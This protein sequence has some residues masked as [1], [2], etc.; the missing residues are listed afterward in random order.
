MLIAKNETGKSTLVS[1]LVA[2]IF[3][4]PT[5]NN[6][7]EFGTARFKNWYGPSRFEG[8]LEFQFDSVKYSIW[9]DFESHKISLSVFENDVQRNLV[10][11]EH[12]PGA[13]KQNL[14]YEAWLK[15]LFGI[16]SREV[17]EATF[18]ITQPLPETTKKDGQGQRD[19]DEGVQELLSGT[20]IAFT[21]AK[22]ALFEDFKKQTKFTRERGFSSRDQIRDGELELVEARIEKLKSE[23][24]RAKDVADSLETVRA[25]LNK[26][27]EDLDAKSKELKEKQETRSSFNEWKRLRSEYDQAILNLNKTQKAFDT[28]NDYRNKIITGTAELKRLYPEYNNPPRT[29]ED[30]LDHLILLDQRISVLSEDVIKIKEQLN[31]SKIKREEIRESAKSL[32]CWGELGKNPAAKIKTGRRTAA[33]LL[34]GWDAF[35][36]DLDEQAKCEEILKGELALIENAGEEVRQALATYDADLARLERELSEA[37]HNL[38][39]VETAFLEFDADCI[40]YNG[41]YGDIE[42]FPCDASDTLKKGLELMRTRNELQKKAKALRIKLTAPIWVRIALIIGFVLIGLKISGMNTNAWIPVT[43]M[44]ALGCLGWFAATPLWLF[45]HG[46]LKRDEI[47]IMSDLINCELKIE[48]IG[49]SLG[50]H[51]DSFN[52]AEIGGLQER[53]NSRDYDRELLDVKRRNLP[54]EKYLED[55]KTRFLQIE[56]EYNIFLGRFRAFTQKYDNV[57]NT[58]ARWKEVKVRRDTVAKKAFVF[59]EQQFGCGPG[60]VE[61][62]PVL[63]RDLSDEWKEVTEILKVSGVGDYIDTVRDL[64]ESM[65]RCTDLWWADIQDEAE[66]YEEFRKSEENL[67]AMINEQEKRL[68]DTEQDLEQKTQEFNKAGSALSL[69]LDKAG[70]SPKHAKLRWT[71]LCNLKKPLENKEMLLNKI[72]AD[73]NV[74]SVDELSLCVTKCQ[75][76]A[77]GADIKWQDLINEKPG[78]P[79]REA[80]GEPHKIDKYMQLLDDQIQVLEKEVSILQDSVNQCKYELEIIEREN[81]LNIAQAELE[82]KRMEERQKDINLQADALAEAFIELESAIRDFHTSHRDRLEGATMK[83]FRKITG[84]ANRTVKIND[85]F[86]ISLDVEGRP[87]DVAQLSKGA[88]DQLYIALR[89]AIADLLSADINLPLIFD[90]PFVTCDEGRLDNIGASL[91]RIA[92][93]FQIFILSHNKRISHWGNPVVIQ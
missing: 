59:A 21:N 68:N 76:R 4:L 84:V 44:V 71:E 7:Q 92:D 38:K 55:V 47:R 27:M 28:A 93:E 57:S 89:L 22:D 15:K 51:I 74:S 90:D 11:G 62:C 54:E 78:L 48:K 37:K 3:G 26:L 42:S 6:P 14:E 60:S 9:R 73:Y 23:I 66:K 32:R 85:S 36:K 56:N 72:L 61:T 77:S 87:C 79:R 16:V 41:K 34:E 12:N 53:L 91:S 52:E 30:D 46:N 58:Y 65:K 43:A 2:T 29:I 45:I 86:Q 1:G 10:S 13:R 19:L 20:G 17:F 69:I 64:I 50:V 70:G 35:Q 75:T 88:Q 49:E 5:R 83:Y 67:T 63:S 39:D 81:P 31:D 33:R 18:C 24:E 8:E 40:K 80:A 25:N 82:L